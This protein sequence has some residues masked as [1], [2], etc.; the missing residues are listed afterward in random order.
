MANPLTAVKR[1][2]L[3]DY[4]RATWQYDVMVGLILLF[5][6]ATPR[7]WFRDQPKPSSIVMLPPE[8][9]E[10]VFWIEPELLSGIP[11]TLRSE[12]AAGFIKNR[13]G[14]KPSQVRVK[15][16]A[17]SEQGLKGYMAFSTP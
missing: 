6:F 9:G 4:A 8:R 13:T 1:F 17:D 16:I 11:E 7:G 2:I 3:W 12:K 10:N 5:I 15:E 14:K